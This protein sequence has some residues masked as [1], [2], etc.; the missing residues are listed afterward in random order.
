MGRDTPKPT[1]K[2][3]QRL[4]KKQQKIN[5][6]SNRVV[7]DEDDDERVIKGRIQYEGGETVFSVPNNGDWTP[8]LF[9]GMRAEQEVMDRYEEEF[10]IDPTA[11]QQMKLFTEDEQV[12]RYA[13]H[14]VFWHKMKLEYDLYSPRAMKIILNNPVA[15]VVMQRSGE[16][17]VKVHNS[18]K[19]DVIRKIQKRAEELS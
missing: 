14:Y 16:F 15:Q 17:N 10:G 9:Q 6:Q 12:E 7:I 4:N 13:K 2:Q 3:R 18:F 8:L 11:P 19:P 1:K 5:E